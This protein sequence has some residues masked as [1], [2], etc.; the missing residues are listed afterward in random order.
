MRR[1]IRLVTILITSFVMALSGLAA[2]SAASASENEAVRLSARFAMGSSLLTKAHETAI[3]KAV[4]TSGTDATFLVTAAAGN[5]TGI[6][7]GEVQSLAK[8]R[9][10][11]VEAYLI[12]LG[13]TKSSVTVKVKITRL[14]IVP[15]T[16]I[17]GSYSLLKESTAS[18]T[19]TSSTQATPVL[20]DGPVNC[21]T[22]GTFTVANS[23]VTTSSSCVGSVI[24]PSGV[25][26]IGNNAFL[27]AS[28]IT[29]LGIPRSVTSI[30]TY[31]F[32]QTSALTAFDVDALNANYET[33]GGVLFNKGVT[34][35]INY[36][37]G[38]TTPTSY[39]IPGTV[40]AIGNSAFHQASSLLTLTIPASVISV[41]ERGVY[42]VNITDV[43]F[44]GNAPTTYV[45][46]SFAEFYATPTGTAK[47]KICASA[48]GFTA[49][50]ARWPV[51]GMGT[52]PLTVA[53][54]C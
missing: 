34:T 39:S 8:N 5:L 1:M 9:G 30:G 7:D 54:V 52:K 6:S 45:T 17:V 4:T 29:S 48:T 51:A 13:V 27:N 50:A 18:T 21:G 36:P 35:L 26:S 47:A 16:K 46:D 41:G 38:K 19:T 32:F 44:L 33:V 10:Q 40:T 11:A 37:N 3:K 49:N 42:A 53:I 14:G 12:K 43:I 15:K 20:S 31:A 28:G 24:I 22:S 2:S 23:V 25:T